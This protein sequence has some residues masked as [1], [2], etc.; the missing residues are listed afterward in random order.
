[1]IGLPQQLAD[2]EPEPDAHIHTSAA[3]AHK[4]MIHV[5]LV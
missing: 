5:H 2:F 3:T 4:A 1:M